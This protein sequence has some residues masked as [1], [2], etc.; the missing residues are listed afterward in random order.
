MKVKKTRSKAKLFSESPLGGNYVDG[1]C[2]RAFKGGKKPS[3]NRTRKFFKQNACFFEKSKRIVLVSAL[4]SNQN[5][6]KKNRK[7]FKKYLEVYLKA[8]ISVLKIRDIKNLYKLA[9][10]NKIKNVVGVDIKWNEPKNPDLVFDQ[11]KKINPNKI[12][13]TILDKIINE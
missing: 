13:K 2:Y 7:I 12:A 1:S 5:I 4:Y 10:K 6:L 9:L 3:A 8:P 11:S